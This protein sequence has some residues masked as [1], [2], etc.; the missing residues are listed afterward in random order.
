MRGACSRRVAGWLGALAVCAGWIGYVALTRWDGAQAASRLSR[1]ATTQPTVDDMAFAYSLSPAFD[2]SE[3]VASA[4]AAIPPPPTVH[5]PAAPEGKVW[6]RPWPQ[7]IAP[8]DAL[9]GAWDPGRR[10]HLEAVIAFLQREDTNAALD[11]LASI[12]W[13]GVH[14]SGGGAW[15]LEESATLLCARARLRIASQGD[16]DAALADLDAADRL[17]AMLVESGNW[18]QWDV[19]IRCRIAVDVE[20]RRMAFERR[21]T[22]SQA[23]RAIEGMAWRR[24]DAVAAREHLA[25]ALLAAWTLK[26]DRSF[27][28]DANGNGWLVLSALP[29]ITKWEVN[30]ETPRRTGAWNLLSVFF[31]DRR[32]V[33]AKI[34]AVVRSVERAEGMRSAENIKAL[35]RRFS[36]LDGPLGGLADSTRAYGLYLRLLQY[37]ASHSAATAAIALSDYRREHGAWPERLSDAGDGWLSERP[38]DPYDG[39]IL[40]YRRLPEE[41]AYLLYAVYVD[42]DDDG[43]ADATWRLADGGNKLIGDLLLDARRPD[44]RM[45]PVLM[46][47]TK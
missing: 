45:D 35:G 25:S 18:I 6:S 5:W 42:G 11:Q 19:G 29:Y 46:D 17:G 9:R 1:E 21:L 7:T 10:G 2:R 16:V 43:G 3:R 20:R 15:R 13:G 36:F 14:L 27:T 39:E 26:L 22:H 28:R 30:A 37:C 32:T 31:N 40:R 8:A 12:E 34:E 47:A 4:L 41:D 24:Q 23:A 38:M 44:A 33:L